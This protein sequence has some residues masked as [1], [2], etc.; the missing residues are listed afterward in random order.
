MEIQPFLGQTRAAQS[1]SDDVPRVDFG[2]NLRS[3][4]GG[5]SCELGTTGWG[6]AEPG[7]CS[8][9]RQLLPALGRG[10]AAARAAAGC[11]CAGNLVS[12]GDPARPPA[13]CSRA[14][15]KTPLVGGRDGS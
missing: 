13:L 9:P 4:P 2:N 15:G 7:L 12:P 8:S 10:Q 14:R 1:I 3:G 11:A 5:S 6:L